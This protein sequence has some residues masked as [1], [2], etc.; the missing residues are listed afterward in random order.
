MSHP[1]ILLIDIETRPILA[2]VWKLWKNDV[3]INQIEEDWHILSWAA[4]WLGD[5]KMMYADQRN[6]RTLHNDK[7]ILKE[8]CKLLN[9]ADIVIGHNS[10]TFDI[11]RI[12]ARLATHGI[13]PPKDYRQIDTLRIARKHFAFTSNKL[14]YLAKHLKLSS[15]KKM[16]KKFNGFELWR[17]CINGNKEAWKEMEAYNKHDVILLEELYNKLKSWDNSINM[18]VYHESTNEGC[19]KCG[20]KNLKKHG[21][22]FTNSGKYQRYYCDN[23]GASFKGKDNLLSKEKRASIKL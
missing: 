14:E 18:E 1:K 19:S 7:A 6:A 5:K 8:M 17:E 11:K 15:G 12:N 2:H 22:R 21:F 3:S 20:S 4:K 10:K 16:S 23:C 13:N 9:E